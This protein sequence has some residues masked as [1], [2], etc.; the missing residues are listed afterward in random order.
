MTL[1][2]TVPSA[3][4]E[5]VRAGRVP[6]TASV[7]AWAGEPLKRGFAEAVYAFAQVERLYNLYGP[8]E[9]PPTPPI[10]RLARVAREHMIGCPIA[11]RAPT[12]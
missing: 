10:A 8:T 6:R 11:K 4:A 2:N 3:M 1:V 5:L 12:S 9:E 7:V